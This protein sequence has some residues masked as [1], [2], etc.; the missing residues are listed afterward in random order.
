MYLAK[1]PSSAANNAIDNINGIDIQAL[2]IGNRI[3]N[4]QPLLI[5]NKPIKII[6][7]GVIKVP[8]KLEA[9]TFANNLKGILI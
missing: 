1:V 7:L 8:F 9:I 6:M 4:K 5:N 3:N 2:S